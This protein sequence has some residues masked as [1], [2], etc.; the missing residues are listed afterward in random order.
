MSKKPHNHK[1]ANRFGIDFYTTKYKCFY[2]N[3]PL[4]DTNRTK[5]HVVPK[6]LGGILSNDNK[7]YACRDCNYLKK[8]MTLEEFKLFL[9]EELRWMNKILNNVKYMLDTKESK[10]KLVSLKKRHTR[11][12]KMDG[13]TK[14]ELKDHVKEAKGQVIGDIPKSDNPMDYL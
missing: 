9:S 6:K 1:V 2:C 12:E 13:M 8:D 10:P 4:N 7:V 11:Q 14:K 5:D 3:T